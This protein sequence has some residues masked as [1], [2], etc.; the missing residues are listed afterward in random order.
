MCA[1]TLSPCSPSDVASFASLL[2]RCL[3]QRPHS[4]VTQSP[5]NCATRSSCG[6]SLQSNFLRHCVSRTKVVVPLYF[7]LWQQLQKRLICNSPFLH[8]R[9][10]HTPTNLTH[11]K[12]CA[13]FLEVEASV[14]MFARFWG[15]SNAG[16]STSG[17]FSKS[18]EFNAN[19]NELWRSCPKDS[20]L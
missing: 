12:S 6:A 16:T 20:A 3:Q 11:V 9:R 18:I 17:T 5:D 8:V 14:R 1:T 2:R 4:L 13:Y 15:S 10:S 19:E 7:Q